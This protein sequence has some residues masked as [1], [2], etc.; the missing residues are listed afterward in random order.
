MR[1][2][3]VSLLFLTLVLTGCKIK[4]TVPAGGSVSTL[5]GTYSCAAGQTCEIDVVDIFFDEVF[6]AT[7]DSGQ[8]FVAWQRGARTLCG[9]SEEP[10]ALATTAGFAGN[11]LFMSI[12]ESD[13]VFHLKPYFTEVGSTALRPL[14][15]AR[16]FN[17]DMYRAGYTSDITDQ[18]YDSDGRK[19]GTLRSEMQVSGPVTYRGQSVMQLDEFVTRTDPPRSTFEFTF[20]TAVDLPNASASILG[21]RQETV[22]PISHLVESDY[23]PGFLQ[24]FDLAPG[25][26]YVTEHTLDL[27]FPNGDGPDTRFNNKSEFI[28]EGVEDITIPAGTFAACRIRRFDT[29]DGSTSEGYNWI[30]VDNGV[31]L[32]EADANFVPRAEVIEGT[33]QGVAL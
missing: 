16:C 22:T 15:L 19:T 4:I 18:L 8:R 11:D 25:E 31:I 3:T 2:A 14:P 10:C 29:V 21:G 17:E 23:M 7:A 28:Y 9:G 5:S 12:L 20:Y 30:G 6:I 24:N 13:Q 33:V 1:K 32:R 27:T 26:G